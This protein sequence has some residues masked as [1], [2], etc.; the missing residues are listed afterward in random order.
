MLKQNC[1]KQYEK[2]MK[3]ILKTIEAHKDLPK[4]TAEEM[5]HLNTC[6]ERGYLLCVKTLRMASG[7]IVAE[8]SDNVRLSKAGYDFLYPKHDIKFI[9][10]ASIAAISVICNIIQLL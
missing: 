5:E 4:L 2:S 3:R 6:V 7:R 9:I 1:R 10:T 8:I